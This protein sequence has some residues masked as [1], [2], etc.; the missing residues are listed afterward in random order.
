M[1]AEAGETEDSRTHLPDDTMLWYAQAIWA[2]RWFGLCCLGVGLALGALA[3]LREPGRRTVVLLR[4]ENP[5]IGYMHR[6]YWDGVSRTIQA[7]L[8]VAAEAFKAS[9]DIAVKADVDPWLLRIEVRHAADGEGR[10]I[11]EQITAQ[12][13]CMR[14]SV[15]VAAAQSAGAVSALQQPDVER[16]MQLIQAMDQLQRQL[17]AVWP[18]WTQV[19]KPVCEDP[20]TDVL[21]DRIFFNEGMLR[22]PF[23]DVPH[24]LRFRRLARAV[25]H[26]SLRTDNVKTLPSS[27]SWRELIGQQQQMT[28]LFLLHWATHDVFSAA[29]NSHSVVIDSLHEMQEPALNP[30]LKY[31]FAGVVGSLGLAF[32]LAVPSYW[33]RQNWAR[34]TARPQ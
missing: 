3:A 26:A 21:P 34:I 11:I 4:G 33:L 12:L 19:E 2:A 6:S 7:Q 25:G 29:A 23:E 15:E 14:R 28:R 10:R 8:T 5:A 22:L 9:A 16:E 1:S 17:A 13:P 31:L 24:A 32:L 30:W 18:E 27:E 20:L